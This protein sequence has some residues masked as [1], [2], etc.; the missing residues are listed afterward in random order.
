M[1]F[2]TLINHLL[3]EQNVNMLDKT[4]CSTTAC[5]I[6]NYLTN[7]SEMVYNNNLVDTS[8][9]L[10]ELTIQIKENANT[11]THAIYY[12]HLDHITGETSHYFIVC[13]MGSSILILQSAVYE[14]SIA[15]WLFP[16]DSE[17]E[18]QTDHDIQIFMLDPNDTLR[19][20]V[21]KRQIDADL[22]ERKAILQRI[23]DCKWSCGNVFPVDE[24]IRE[25]IPGIA[26]L[27][28]NW[29]EQSLETMCKTYTQFF[30]CFLKPANIRGKIRTGSKPASFKWVGGLLINSDHSIV[31]I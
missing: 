2:K 21:S 10:A 13:Q 7:E 22:A 3:T 9:N 31:T 18:A 16:D 6:Y 5:N 11:N 1:D 14:F 23:R 19:F 26:S 25:F 24:F 27:E 12:V 4:K 15:D 20:E 30:S 29:T 8:A 17:I 28:G